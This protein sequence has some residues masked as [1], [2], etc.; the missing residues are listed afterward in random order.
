MVNPS[1]SWDAADLR[2]MIHQRSQH[3]LNCGALQPIQTRYE[4]VGQGGME[5]VVRVV[6][7]LARKEQSDLNQ[8]RQ[9]QAGQEVNP[10][11]PYDPDLFVTDLSATHLCLLNKYNVVEDHILIV[12]RA[13]EEQDSWLTGADLAALASCLGGID[14]LGFYNGGRLAGAS[15]RHKH[16]QVI[17]PPLGPEGGQLPL[18]RVIADLE[19]GGDSP[20]A[21]PP[22]TSQGYY[23]SPMF[24]FRHGILP[25]PP[26]WWTGDKAANLLE[27]HYRHLLTHLGANLSAAPRPFPYNLLVTR[28]WMVG[29]CRRQDRYQ[30][31]P[32]NSLGFAGSLLVK[33]ETQLALVKSLG[34]MTIL[35]QVACQS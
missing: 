20:R 5:F 19:M 3:A 21:T 26:G 34:P 14:G 10:F 27:Q 2:S 33:D 8:E 28:Q 18:A 35:Q 29:V 7:N 11:L 4:F 32:V 13:F 16:L 24:S 30:S 12:T 25:L 31:I 1:P 22:E 6:A 15:Q 9:R 17:P 23:Q